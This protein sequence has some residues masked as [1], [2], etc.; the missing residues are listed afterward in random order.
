MSGLV[1]A[2]FGSGQ[3][4][5]DLKKEDFLLQIFLAETGT[6]KHCN[7][8]QYMNSLMLTISP[9]GTDPVTRLPSCWTLFFFSPGTAKAQMP[10][11]SDFGT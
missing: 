6:A 10:W 11:T 1:L 3:C 9:Q 8:T 7:R 2:S 4:E 5:T